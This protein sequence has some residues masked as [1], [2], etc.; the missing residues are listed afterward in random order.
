MT[1]PRAVNI[2]PRGQ[3][4]RLG[5]GVLMLAVGVVLVAVLIA[6]GAQPAWLLLAFPLFFTGALGVLQAREGT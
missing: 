5:L 3:R 2:G 6:R 1:R 4:R